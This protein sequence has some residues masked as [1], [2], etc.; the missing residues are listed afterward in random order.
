MIGLDWF[1]STNF[2][3]GSECKYDLAVFHYEWDKPVYRPPPRGARPKLKKNITAEWREWAFS[4]VGANVKM[5]DFQ[6]VT[7]F[8]TSE[9][10]EMIQ[11][12]RKKSALNK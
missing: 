7:I 12:M 3:M 1:W 2:S 10:L 4:I 9:Y 11:N 8:I 6:E 5:G